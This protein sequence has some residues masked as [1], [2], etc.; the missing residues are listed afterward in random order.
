VTIDYTRHLRSNGELMA[1][2]VGRDLDAHVP[3]CPEWNVAKLTIHTG[4]HHR[5]VADAVRGGGEPPPNPAKPGLRG[6]E[7]VEW[8]RRGW[9]ELADLLDETDDET[10]AWS[11]AGD[12][13]VGFWRR[14]TAL[15]TLVHRWDA[16]NATGETTPF[17]PEL[18][19]D[20][21]DEMFFVHGPSGDWSYKGK[22]ARLHLR[23]T[24]ADA[25]WTLLLKDGET[26]IVARGIEGP[27]DV[28]IEARAEDLGLFLWGRRGSDVLSTTGDETLAASLVRWLEE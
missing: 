28:T 27:P 3:S 11:W 17:D 24:D 8:F 26:P 2:A 6:D 1:T 21:V 10:P 25:A 4:Q 16:E 23:T 22:P 15:E 5:W 20:V 9:S 12:N 18:S 13:R 14:R 19:A 7:L